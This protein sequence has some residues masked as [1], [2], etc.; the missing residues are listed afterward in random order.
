M[1]G[2]ALYAVL[3]PLLTGLVV[4][5]SFL[6]YVWFRYVP[7]V[8]RI[9]DQPPMFSPARVDPDPGEEVRF[10]TPDGIDLAGTYYHAFTPDR[11]GV[12]VFCPEY[13]GDRWSALLYAD[14]LREAGFD[15]FTFDFRNHGDS[16]CDPFYRP[17]QWV[18]DLEV[19]DLKAALAYLASRPDADPAGVGLFGMS[20]GGGTGLCVAADDP[21]VW[22]VVSDGAFPTHGTMLAYIIRWAEIYVGVKTLWRNMPRFVFDFVGWAGRTRTHWRVGRTYPSLERAVSRLSPRPWLMI[23]GQRDTLIVPE[24]AK[25]LFTRAGQPKTAWFVPGAKHNRCQE[26]NPVAYRERIVEFFRRYAPRES[27][28]LGPEPELVVQTVGDVVFRPIMSEVAAVS[29]PG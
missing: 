18:S 29:V 28:D 26:V 5:A 10:R 12:I 6:V 22:G 24:I 15:L 17:L 2:Y 13:L 21:S 14:G 3:I 9:F 25:D 8:G 16:I 27:R 20:R 4:T 19:V 7:I 1:L 11:L 23:H